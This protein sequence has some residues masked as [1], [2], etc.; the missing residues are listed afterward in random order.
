MTPDE[1]T[2]AMRSCEGGDIE[3]NHAAADDLLCQIL[4][5][6]GYDEGVAVF[7]AMTKWYA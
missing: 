6:L 1:F 7:D 4:I 5:E 3:A 2:E